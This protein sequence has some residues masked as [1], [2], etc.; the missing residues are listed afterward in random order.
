MYYYSLFPIFLFFLFLLSLYLIYFSLF[1]NHSIDRT[2]PGRSFSFLHLPH[3]IFSLYFS[4]LHIS[5]LVALAPAGA[6]PMAPS[7]CSPP[8]ASA[9]RPPA[10]PV[11][12]NPRVWLPCAASRARLRLGPAPRPA[13][14]ASVPLPLAAPWPCSPVRVLCPLVLPA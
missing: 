14:G 11:R 7:A 8:L 2:P 9:A 3:S 10:P 13:A 6:L 12:P 5:P 4:F 1:P